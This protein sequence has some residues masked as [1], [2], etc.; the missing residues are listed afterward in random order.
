MESRGAWN[1]Y[2]KYI[3]YIPKGCLNRA[4]LSEIHFW[5]R[6]AAQKIVGVLDSVGLDETH[7]L[8]PLFKIAETGQTQAEELLCAYE[9]QWKKSVI[10]VYSEYSY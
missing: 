2:A 9:R 1:L 3:Q 5:S 7:Y 8:K 10:P 4:K 6:F